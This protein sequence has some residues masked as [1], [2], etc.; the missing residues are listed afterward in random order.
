M[1]VYASQACEYTAIGPTGVRDVSREGMSGILMIYTPVDW[2][3]GDPGVE[4]EQ[5]RP[6]PRA[7][8]LSQG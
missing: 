3:P 5:E 7:H 4:Q 1:L 6:P 2:R 8:T